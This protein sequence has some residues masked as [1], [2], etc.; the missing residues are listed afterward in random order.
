MKNKYR[1]SILIL[2]YNTPFYKTKRTLDSIINQDF[3]DYEI[4]I[5]DDG[6]SEVHFEEIEEYLKNNNVKSYKLLKNSENVGTVKH[7]YNVLCVSKGKYIKAIGS[8][9]SLHGNDTI[10]RMYNFMESSKSSF[11]FGRM[12]KYIIKDKKLIAR[13]DFIAPK[14]INLYKRK[15]HKLYSM[16]DIIVC[17]DWIS[18]ASM[19]GKRSAF[20]HY[21]G[22]LIGV[23]KYSDDILQIL[24]FDKNNVFEF[25][26]SYIVDYE[27]GEGVSTSGASNSPFKKALRKDIDR[28]IELADR[29]YGKNIL[30][31]ILL[32]IGKN[33]QSMIRRIIR[34]ILDTIDKKGC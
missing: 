6:S 13:G 22:K 20:I 21:I 33:Q 1:F 18:G 24:A 31:R 27:F 34:S 30:Y 9:D 28:S 23:S 26:D 2:T 17:H 32:H 8:G 7:L 3:K 19:F 4:I 16:L 5:S 12:K 25:Y 14:R 29:L 15:K 10:S 11:A